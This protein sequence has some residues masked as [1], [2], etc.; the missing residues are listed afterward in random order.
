MVNIVDHTV[1][2]ETNDENMVT[3]VKVKDKAIPVTDHGGL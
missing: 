3:A 2:C 1:F